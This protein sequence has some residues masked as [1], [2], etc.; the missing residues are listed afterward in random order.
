MREDFKAFLDKYFLADML[1]QE[2]INML[3]IVFYAGMDV[4]VAAGYNDGYR[5][6]YSDGYSEGEDDGYQRCM[7]EEAD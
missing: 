7:D 5:D 3:E 1:P 6:G 4:G 2:T